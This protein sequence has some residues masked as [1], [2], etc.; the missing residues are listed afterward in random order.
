[1]A[2]LTVLLLITGVQV[3]NQYHLALTT[4]HADN[5]CGTLDTLTLGNHAVG[6]LVVL[7]EGVS[8]LLG[9]FLGAPLVAHELEAGTSLFGWTQSVTRKHWFAVKTGWILLAAAVYAGAVT[10]LVTWWSVGLGIA[11]GVVLRRTLPAVA[12]MLGGF[13]AVRL[14]VVYLFRPHY[15]APITTTFGSLARLRR[16]VQCG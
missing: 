12:V 10:A 1:L 6:F 3:G 5:S 11:A 8:A 16:L 7:T 15:M 2:A 4:C 14:L 9:L 13:V